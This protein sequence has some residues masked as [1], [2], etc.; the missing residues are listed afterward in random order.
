MANIIISS[1]S[2]VTKVCINCLIEQLQEFVLYSVHERDQTPLWTLDSQNT[3]SASCKT[4]TDFPH[5][6]NEQDQFTTDLSVNW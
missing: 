6:T 1:A 4:T 5:L 2:H 3:H